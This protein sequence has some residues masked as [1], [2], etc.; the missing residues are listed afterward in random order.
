MST[1]ETQTTS[2]AFEQI[3]ERPSD[4][5]FEI[6]RAHVLLRE[7]RLVGAVY[8]SFESGAAWDGDIMTT[9]QSFMSTAE[10]EAEQ[11]LTKHHRELITQSSPTETLS[12]YERRA[13]I[14]TRDRLATDERRVLGGIAV[15]QSHRGY[16]AGMFSDWVATAEFVNQITKS[17]AEEADYV[18]SHHQVPEALAAMNVYLPQEPSKS[19]AFARER[20]NATLLHTLGKVDISS[21]IFNKLEPLALRV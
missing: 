4:Y 21:G 20:L 13:L 7:A 8:L 6:H 11:T 17:Q 3:S 12:L 5:V 2:V 10:P 14:A 18:R 1:H 15:F 9:A 16:Q 19:E